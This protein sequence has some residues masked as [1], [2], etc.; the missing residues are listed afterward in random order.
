MAG[1]QG[2]HPSAVVLELLLIKWMTPA[3]LVDL[4]VPVPV[5]VPE[6]STAL[7]VRVVAAEV[8]VLALV[9]VMATPLPAHVKMVTVW[10]PKAYHPVCWGKI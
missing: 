4:L 8:P 5:P 9:G 6:Q 3:A 2:R 7:A 10:N 1:A